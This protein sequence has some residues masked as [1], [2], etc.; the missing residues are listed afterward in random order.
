MYNRPI[1]TARPVRNYRVSDIYANRIYANVPMKGL[2]PPQVVKK[3]AKAL[4]HNIEGA[5]KLEF[6]VGGCVVYAT[7]PYSD[8]SGTLNIAVNVTGYGSDRVGVS[9]I[10]NEPKNRRTF[11]FKAFLMNN[12]DTVDAMR[13]KMLTEIEKMLNKVAK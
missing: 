11:G 6:K 12:F 5:T 8:D 10:G 2:Q 3:I 1:R 13:E 7:V 4:Y 9:V